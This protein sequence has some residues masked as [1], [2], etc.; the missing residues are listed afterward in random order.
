MSRNAEL[1]FNL[2]VVLSCVAAC[3]YVLWLSVWLNRY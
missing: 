2:L 3:F 1:K